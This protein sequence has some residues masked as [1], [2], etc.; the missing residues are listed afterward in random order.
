MNQEEVIIFQYISG[1]N[2]VIGKIY[3]SYRNT[4]LL[5]AYKYTRDTDLSLDIIQ[6]IME[7]LIS[8]PVEKRKEYFNYTENRLLAYLTIFIKNRCLDIIKKKK[9]RE[10]IL[11]SIRSYIMMDSTNEG[12][13]IFMKDMLNTVT[14]GLQPRE[15]EILQLHLEGYANDEIAERLNITYNTVK[16]NIYESKKKVKGLWK[17]FIN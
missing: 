6:D 5:I 15:A 1:N 4:L 12:F 7:K 2:E 9:N 10:K 8:L 17:H 16:N 11:H 3:L 13:T 14:K